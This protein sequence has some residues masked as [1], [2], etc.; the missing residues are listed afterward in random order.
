MGERARESWWREWEG[1]AAEVSRDGE[2]VVWLLTCDRYGDEADA[3]PPTPLYKVLSIPS[4]VLRAHNLEILVSTLNVNL[5][6][7]I[8][9][10]TESSKE[11]LLVPKL[12][13]TSA[14][15]LPVP[16]P[17]H[18]TLVLGE[19]LNS[20]IAFGRFTSNT[21]EDVGDMVKVVVD[22]PTPAK[23]VDQDAHTESVEVNMETGLE[24]IAT[25]RQSIQN[26]IAYERGWY[27]SGLPVLS[28]WLVEDLQPSEPIKPAMQ[29]LVSSILDDVEASITKEDTAR[30]HTLASLAATPS[31]SESVV[32]HL[33]TWAEKS[34]T[35]LR[36]ELDEAFSSPNWHKMSWW[37]LFW[38][39]D[40]V[41]MLSTEILERR[42]LTS[43][44]KNSIYLAGRMNQAGYPEE[45]QQQTAA[46]QIP[47]VTT[48]ETAP[49][50]EKPRL[51]ISTDVRNPIPWP[52]HIATA[53]TQL[54]NDIV[55]PLQALA[56]RLLLQTFSTTSLSSAASALLYVTISS[57][58]VFE[59]AAVGVLGLTFS[60]RRMQRLWEGARETW[61]ATVRE[62]GRRTLKTTEELVRFIICTKDRDDAMGGVVEEE[63]VLER[64][65]AREAVGRVRQALERIGAKHGV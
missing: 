51:D 1:G 29:R 50:A 60:L 33:L 41:T 28:Q 14:R 46:S 49:T 8:T 39:V 35:E 42:W 56:Q 43:A 24:A 19:G 11:S 20:A 53:R 47:E 21:T 6:T 26:S 22:L 23:E 36:D 61:E 5:P 2:S 15:G 48:D 27:K 4:R 62:E 57:F 34:H 63:G 37:K 16:Y 55:P 13:A 58:S 17:V 65:K 7:T 38:R 18:K 12:Q 44:E 10:S 45:I 64:R 31:T 3:Q 52:E 59:G 32:N 25:F 40:D 9:S 30:L 54:T